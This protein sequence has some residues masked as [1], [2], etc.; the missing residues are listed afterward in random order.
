MR[1]I[2]SVN[3][4]LFV[5]E[6]KFLVQIWARKFLRRELKEFPEK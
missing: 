2:S 5:N 4:F 6:D 1:T 3:I